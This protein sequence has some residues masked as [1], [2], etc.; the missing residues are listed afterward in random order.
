MVIG[1]LH[2][3]IGPTEGHYRAVLFHSGIQLIADDFALPVVMPRYEEFCRNLYLLWLV[4]KQ[5]RLVP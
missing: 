4:P 5:H 1:V 3:G 2:E